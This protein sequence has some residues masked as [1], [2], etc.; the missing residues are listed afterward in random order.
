MLTN[1]DP[2]VQRRR[3]TSG[4]YNNAMSGLILNHEYYL[5]SPGRTQSSH[6]Q[7][8]SLRLQS[9]YIVS[10][11][12]KQPSIRELTS[13]QG[14]MMEVIP[15]LSLPACCRS[16][17]LSRTGLV[18][19][20]VLVYFYLLDHRTDQYYSIWYRAASR[21]GHVVVV[22]RRARPGGGPGASPQSSHGTPCDGATRTAGA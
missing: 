17:F 20:R 9:F 16:Y 22:A 11:K 15:A 4:L 2:V 18:L 7:V 13:M 21:C 8:E 10:R 3:F 1:A 5:Y 19:I 12:N 14:M 6:Q